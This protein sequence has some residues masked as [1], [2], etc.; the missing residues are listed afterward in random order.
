MF[1][2]DIVNHLK[3]YPTMALKLN[4]KGGQIINLYYI[5]SDRNT[6]VVDIRK[7]YFDETTY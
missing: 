1:R 4:F 2:K 5:S 7:Y 3:A 6:M